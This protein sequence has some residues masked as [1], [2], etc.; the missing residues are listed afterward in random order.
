MAEYSINT[1]KLIVSKTDI[2][3]IILQA[4]EAFCEVSGYLK[5]ELVGQNHNLVRH[6][7]MPQ[8]VFKLLWIKLLDGQEVYAFVKNERKNGDYYWVYSTI[9]PDIDRHGNIISFTSVRKRPNKK[10]IAIIEPFYKKLCA[11]E[12][13][14]RYGQSALAL[15]ELLNSK[16]MKYNKLISS[17]QMTG[18]L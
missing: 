12:E 14:S 7:D 11:L 17:L 1:S 2:D 5:S 4:N 3:G 13:P 15:K 10:A 9:T 18:N 6:K 8:I 16:N